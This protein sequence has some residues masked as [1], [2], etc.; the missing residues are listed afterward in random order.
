MK[1]H[2]K[3]TPR[4]TEAL[5]AEVDELLYG[6]ARGGGKTDAGQVWMIEPRYV[7][8]P[9]YRGLVIRKNSDDL[10]DWVDRARRMY[11]PLGADFKGTP[12]EIHFPSG[13][14]IRT[15]HL[16][17]ENAYGKYQGHEYQKML[18]EELTKIPRE[19]DYEKLRGSCRSTVPG[20]KARLMATTNPDGDG[21]EWVRDRWDCENA[22]K[23]V[24]SR[25]DK[26]T[27]HVMTRLFIPA[28]VE[29]NPHLMEADPGYV[30]ML[31]SITDP[32]LREQW[33]HGS[34][35]E[36]KIE[37]AY[38]ARQLEEATPRIGNV[39]HDPAV[40]VDTWWDLGVG[41]AMAIWLTQNVGMEIHVIGYLEG[42]GE[43]VPYY[44]AELQRL[45]SERGYVYG[46]HYWP[47][48]G[49]ARELTTGVSRKE[50]AEKLGLRVNIVSDI[51][52]DDGI[53]A[54]RNIFH[55]CWF[56]ATN[57][58]EGLRVLKNYRKERDEKRD[59]WK[60]KPDHNWASHGSDAFRYMAVGQGQYKNRSRGGSG[61]YV[62]NHADRSR[63]SG[64]QFVPR[65]QGAILTS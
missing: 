64:G 40:K 9:A 62:P 46:G 48:D 20:L 58:K 8:N 23:K 65:R 4:Q 47:H 38:Y 7:N 39:P 33:R 27:G 37:G 29:D 19:R 55:R 15:G 34:W 32:V 60:N 49:E 30:A 6:G 14:I 21:Y 43:G 44:V 1:V 24:R 16:K 5:L 56:D 53:Q 35:R 36:P 22:D 28:F 52:V 12:T 31:N 41:D 18:L 11:E 63:R 51:G 26:E 2:W 10:R 61:Q 13:A 25:T 45:A 17:D 57:C 50:T 42:E 54:V 3:P 59:T